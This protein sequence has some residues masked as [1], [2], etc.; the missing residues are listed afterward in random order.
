VSA[1]AAPVRVAVVGAGRMGAVHLRAVTESSSTTVSA[2]VDPDPAARRT[3]GSFGAKAL[4][5]VAEL[6]KADLAEAAIVAV[7][8]S[9]HAAICLELLEAG[10]PTLC[11]KPAGLDTATTRRLAEAADRTRTPLQVGYW[12]RFVPVLSALRAAID[13]GAF[14]PI[15]LVVSA[16][17]DHRPPPMAFRLTSG[18]LVVDMGVHEFDQIRWLT[19]QEFATVSWASSG[20]G[21][22]PE[23]DG[24]PE[25]GAVLARLSGGTLAIVTL[26]RTYPRGDMCRVEVLGPENTRCE[27]F[28]RPDDGDR[29]FVDAVAR[30]ADAFA[31]F[32]RGGTWPGASIED[33]VAALEVAERV[34]LLID[35]GPNGE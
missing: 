1:A 13:S 35:R 23:V 27:E 34:K 7:P 3:A 11:E 9:R 15:S 16:Q 2:V 26:G 4:D 20:V 22:E 28:L 17:W 5:S 32:V 12:R 31:S 24:D 30:Q 8:T 21:L 6:L 18:G 14:G 25:S 29:A 19:G 10:I 33:A